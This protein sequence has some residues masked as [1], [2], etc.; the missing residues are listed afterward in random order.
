MAPTGKRN[1]TWSWKGDKAA[2]QRTSKGLEGKEQG[3]GGCDEPVGLS[4]PYIIVAAVSSAR[5]RPCVRTAAGF[6]PRERD[7]GK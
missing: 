3:E 5:G 6:V 1:D 4:R 2:V 7:G